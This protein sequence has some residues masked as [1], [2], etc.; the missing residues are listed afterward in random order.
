MAGEVSGTLKGVVGGRG[1]CRNRSTGASVAVLVEPG[2][3]WSCTAA[4]MDAAPD[5]RVEVALRGV[6]N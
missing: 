2:G 3:F 1:T 4:G 5:D 6:A